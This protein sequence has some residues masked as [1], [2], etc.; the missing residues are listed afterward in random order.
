MPI[1][2]IHKEYVTRTEAKRNQLRQE[3]RGQWGNEEVTPNDQQKGRLN[4][5]FT[6]VA[7]FVVSV[8]VLIVTILGFCQPL[9]QE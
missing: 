6:T 2:M 7:I 9:V 3:I 5:E 1:T 4:S 8:L